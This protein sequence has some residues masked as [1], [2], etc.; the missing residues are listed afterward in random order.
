MDQSRFGIFQFH[1]HV[2]CQ[3]EVRVLVDRAWDKAGYVRD[4]TEYLRERVG[5]GWSGLDGGK[6][7]LSDVITGEVG[8]WIT[9]KYGCCLNS[10]IVESEG[11]FGL[12]HGNLPGNFGYIL[13]ELS[14]NVVVIAED[15]R[16]LQLKTDGNNIFGILLRESVGLIDFELMLE[17]EFLIV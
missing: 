16:L 10:R 9:F 7:N 1:G 6:V 12:R 5:E 15:E 14:P 8:K 3:T 17:E 11:C 2:S 13:V 4:R